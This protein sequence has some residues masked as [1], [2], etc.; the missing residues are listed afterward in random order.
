MD[1][2]KLNKSLLDIKTGVLNFL[3]SEKGKLFV[4][5][6][7]L[8]AIVS[9]ISPRLTG[10]VLGP[11]AETS[12]ANETVLLQDCQSNLTSYSSQ[13]SQVQSALTEQKSLNSQLSTQIRDNSNTIVARESSLTTCQ[14]DLLNKTTDLANAQVS[15]AN[16]KNDLSSCQNSSSS[17]QSNYDALAQNYANRY[18]CQLNALGF[19]Y[20]AY[21]VVENNIVCLLSGTKA[22]N[23][24]V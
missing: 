15:L 8:A 2:K 10:F 11:G 7:I 22:I 24:T 16:T 13:L 12:G 1:L 20:K 3:K 21:A 5:V 19:N 17:M 4:A 23:C 6:V 14:N 9:V 18:C